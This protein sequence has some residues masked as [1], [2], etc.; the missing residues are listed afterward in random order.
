LGHYISAENRAID[1]AHHAVTGGRA[2]AA[3]AAPCGPAQLFWLWVWS[4]LQAA[5]AILARQ[6][7]RAASPRAPWPQARFSPPVDFHF[8]FNFEFH[9]TLTIHKNSFKISK[10]VEMCMNARIFFCVNPYG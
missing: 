6:V 3:R 7:K 1:G 8:K 5:L 2:H 4:S 9:N 10:F